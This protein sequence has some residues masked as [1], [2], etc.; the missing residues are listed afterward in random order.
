M[1]ILIAYHSNTKNTEKVANTIKGVLEEE[2]QDVVMKLAKEVDPV[3]LSK[4]DLIVLGSGTYNGSIGKSVKDL[5]AKATE[6]PSKFVL[7]CTHM[8]PDRNPKIFGRTKKKIEEGG[9]TII[10]ETDFVG[11]ALGLSEE[12]RQKMMGSMPPERKAQM[13][14]WFEAIKGKPLD[15]WH[16]KYT[17]QVT[18]RWVGLI[19][20]FIWM[21][22]IA[23]KQEV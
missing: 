13:E 10:G 20:H 14:Q 1:N 6:F 23:V 7:F 21:G 3:R 8:Q 19:S 11:D 15:Q 9:A 22:L 17:G 12:F 16:S 4:Y 5:I 18:P 2:G